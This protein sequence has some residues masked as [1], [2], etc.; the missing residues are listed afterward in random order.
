[1]DRPKEEGRKLVERIEAGP[2]I[3]SPGLTLGVSVVSPL[4]R[5]GPSETA[6]RKAPAAGWPGMTY[7]PQPFAKAMTAIAAVLA[8]SSTPAFAQD[9]AA[10]EPVAETTAETPPASDPLAAEPASAAPVAA[11]TAATPPPAPKPKVETSKPGTASA[12]TGSRAKTTPARSNVRRASAAA[13]AATPVAAAAAAPVAAA[14]EAVQLPP[15]P[16]PAAEPVAEPVAPPVAEPAPASD[17]A[18]R[19]MADLMANDLLP[20]GAAALGLLALGGA[21]M[22]NR[23]R[24]RRREDAEFEARQQALAITEEEPPTLNLD[25]RAEVRPGPAFGRPPIHDP[26]PERKFPAEQAAL[27]PAAE[28]PATVPDIGN[29]PATSGADFMIRRAGKNAEKPV[30]QG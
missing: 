28:A 5:P 22:A 11:D 25:R 24:K 8:F 19:L 10:P 23:R 12:S 3:R 17:T 15:A 16:P 20:A 2:A 21:A 7:Q 26:V 9:T 29:W 30:G 27:A 13:A 4:D 14:P 18:D 1:M 6:R